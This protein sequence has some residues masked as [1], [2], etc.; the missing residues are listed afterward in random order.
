MGQR[1]EGCHPARR[2]SPRILGCHPARRRARRIEGSAPC[3]QKWC[4]QSLIYIDITYLFVYVL[5]YFYLHRVPWG[6][7]PGSLKS[8][9]PRLGVG[10]G[11]D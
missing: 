11:G 7:H 8:I 9:T 1:I 5:M 2:I 4:L 10:G 6:P 3:R